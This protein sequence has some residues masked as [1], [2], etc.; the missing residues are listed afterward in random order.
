MSGVLR[1]HPDYI[2]EHLITAYDWL[3][4]EMVNRVGLPPEDVKYPV[5]F[6]KQWQSAEKPRPDLRGIRH[7]WRIG[8]AVMLECE[9]PDE[10]VLLSDFDMWHAVLSGHYLALN[11]TD[12]D[13][14]H[15]RCPMDK[16]GA[17]TF[18]CEEDIIKSWSRVF[19]MN[20]VNDFWHVNGRKII[21]G[22]VWEIRTDQ[23]R[24]VTRFKTT[25]TLEEQS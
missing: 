23:V 21:Q 19:D 6:F 16:S 2:D 11:E 12:F 15:E 9:L 17:L 24:S 14:F 4:G 22:T 5:W 20:F 3:I 10:A 18:E 7:Y 25:K 1:C 13:T 8:D